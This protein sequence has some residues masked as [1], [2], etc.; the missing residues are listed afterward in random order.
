[1]SV[2][3]VAIEV[4]H[5]LVGTGQWPPFPRD[6]K[7]PP[8][9]DKLQSVLDKVVKDRPFD[10][11]GVVILNFGPVDNPHR[12]PRGA[13]HNHSS[14]YPI[15]SASKLAIAYAVFQLKADVQGVLDQLVATIKPPAP[16]I[17]K[18][19]DL[20]TPLAEYW[21]SIPALKK[22][23]D[24]A[25][26]DLTALFDEPVKTNGRWTVD[27]SGISTCGYAVDW[28]SIP[29]RKQEVDKLCTSHV[30]EYSYEQADKD[31]QPAEL[32]K[33]QAAI[34][35]LN[36][37]ERLWM[38]LRWSDNLAAT[39]AAIS[40]GQSVAGAPGKA[41]A[42]T[43]A[44]IQAVLRE[45]GLGDIS[46]GFWLNYAWQEPSPPF[47]LMDLWDNSSKLQISDAQS[48]ARLLMA[49][50][51]R[52][53]IASE[54]SFTDELLSLLRHLDPIGDIFNP[55]YTNLEDQTKSGPANWAELVHIDR[56]QRYSA[57]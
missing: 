26:P 54:G 47:P 27:F 49:V 48:L 25:V 29:A 31:H 4:A 15:G 22:L 45:S 17:P 12:P 56:H 24:L 7:L 16:A 32:R 39:E 23:E 13:Y 41:N 19:A 28:A 57:G 55:T 14:R 40:I 3:A 11:L 10:Q 21:Q 44:Y 50:V 52:N 51:N 46:Q 38:T 20:Q 53:L 43:L 30:H 37:A 34:D 33:W 35:G 2:A 36:F 8:V 42:I 1:M 18:L 9:F 6:T 5:W